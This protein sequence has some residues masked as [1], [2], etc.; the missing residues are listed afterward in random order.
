MAIVSILYIGCRKEKLVNGNNG[1]PNIGSIALTPSN[2][3]IADS[4]IIERQLRWIA[5]GIPNLAQ[6]DTAV[7]HKVENLCLPNSGVFFSSNSDIQNE[8]SLSLSLNFQNSVYTDVNNRFPSNDFDSSI[9]YQFIY[10]NCQF[11][12]GVS[13]PEL[14]IADKN[15]PF[16][17]VPTHEFNK[18]ANN[19][20]YFLTSLGGGGHI[21]SVIIDEDNIDDYYVWVVSVHDFCNEGGYGMSSQSIEIC[22]GDGNCEE[23]YGETAAN[24]A[25]CPSTATTSN[26]H[27]IVGTHDLFILDLQSRNDV[28]NKNSNSHPTNVY[29]EGHLKGKYD[30]IYSY[31]ISNPTNSTTLATP[32]KLVDLDNFN[33]STGTGTQAVDWL[34]KADSWGGNAEI[35]RC[36][37]KTNGST[38]CNRGTQTLHRCDRLL[39]QNYDPTLH[40]IYLII[41]E[42][43][44]SGTKRDPFI[45]EMDANVPQNNA[46]KLKI[47]ADEFAWTYNYVGGGVNSEIFKIPAPGVGS[48]ATANGWSSETR[49]IEGVSRTGLKKT[50]LLDGEMEVTI[51]FFP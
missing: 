39:Y 30:I 32:L 24:C 38:N 27:K 19:Y 9:F 18:Q 34:W 1:F 33:Q 43:D 44:K 45:N 26:N 16:V 36:K 14:D 4:S 29:Q 42:N 40:N 35:P 10:D 12:I 37:T 21:D 22:D 13:I 11:I 15:K 47:Q 8:L 51:G 46:N 48:T 31:A 49:T 5:R 50:F 6:F 25:D 3:T 7:Q 2:P 17:V 20:G 41:F 28:L 23:E